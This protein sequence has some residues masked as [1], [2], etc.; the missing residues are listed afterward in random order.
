MLMCTGPAGRPAWPQLYATAREVV[1]RHSSCCPS[2]FLG[3]CELDI[4]SDEVSVE[5]C[6]V[7]GLVRTNSPE[8]RRTVGREGDERN[9]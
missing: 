9:A 7:D 8:L 6:L 1:A 4:V 3:H 2:A 5:M